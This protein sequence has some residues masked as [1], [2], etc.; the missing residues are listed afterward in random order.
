MTEGGA[1]RADG[2]V[3]F[4]RTLLGAVVVGRGRQVFFTEGLFDDACRRGARF[5]RERHR[6]GTHVGDEAV[7]VQALGHAHR[8]LR[9][10]A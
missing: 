8:L 1:R 10:Q 9:T 3:S 2:L 5:A 4:L 6:V 7:F